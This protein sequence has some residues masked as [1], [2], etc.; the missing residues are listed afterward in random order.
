MRNKKFFY[1]D[2]AKVFDEAMNKYDLFKRL[3]I[4]F[5]DLL[6]G[7]LKNKLLLDAGCGTGWF[8]REAKKRGAIVVSLDL[9]I[10]LLNQV[11]RKCET[12][13]VVGD[14]LQFPFREG[15]FDIVIS[16]EVIEHTV[17]PKKAVLEIF[18]V[19]K[20]G[21]TV[22]LTTPNRF[23]YFSIWIA[24]LI[25]LRPYQGYENW[26]SWS[27]LKKWFLEAGFTIEIIKGFHLFPYISS[28]FYPLLDYLDRF[29]KKTGPL[30]LNIAVK[31]SKKKEE[32]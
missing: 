3:K 10:A 7:N 29:G 9:G 8:S 25:R 28:F 26:A 24:N 14:T 11:K 16:T 21:G 27:M 18:R 15:S 5:D 12:I 31:G 30:M 22:V 13:K 17:D 32:E 2:F 19:I 20:P 6:R 1:E 4:I 23:W